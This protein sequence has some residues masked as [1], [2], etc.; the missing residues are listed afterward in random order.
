MADSNV[1]IKNRPATFEY[2]IEDRLKA[3]MVLTGSEIKSIRNGKVSFNDSYCLFEKGELWVKSL[4]IAEYVNAG[5]AGH[6]PTRV[7]KLLLTRKEIKKWSDKV[8]EKGY[9]IIPLAVFINENGIAKIEI[10]LGKGKK[11]HD[12]RESI[13]SRDV[14]REMKRFLK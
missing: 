3:G 12:K 11:L 6:D 9:S 10:G 5:Y 4:H 14:E 8:K 13:R 1:Y 2:A 7:R